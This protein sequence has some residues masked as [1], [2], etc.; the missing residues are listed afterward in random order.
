MGIGHCVE[1]AALTDLHSY[2]GDDLDRVV[3]DPFSIADE[4]LRRLRRADGA[5]DRLLPRWTRTRVV[6]SELGAD[7]RLRLGPRTSPAS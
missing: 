4:I 5:I 6:G 3:V 2:P 1:R 7:P